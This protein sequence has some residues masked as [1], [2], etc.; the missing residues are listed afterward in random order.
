MKAPAATVDAQ[1]VAAAPLATAVTAVIAAAAPPAVTT[2][3]TAH[4]ATTAAA[5]THAHQASPLA[6]VRD[7]GLL[8]QYAN[9]FCPE[10]S[11]LEAEYASAVV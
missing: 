7:A 1:V 3:A 2:T 4:T 6:S 5:A 9:I 10:N 8:P 11:L